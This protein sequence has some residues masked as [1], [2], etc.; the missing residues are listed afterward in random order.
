MKFTVKSLLP[1]GSV[2]ALWGDGFLTDPFQ[3]RHP[4][5]GQVAVLQYHPGALFDCLV[6][7]LSCYGSLSL[8][9]GNGLGLTP[10][11]F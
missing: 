4:A 9:K 2:C 11:H 1:K 6:N 8:P 10:S 5:G 7:H 3:S